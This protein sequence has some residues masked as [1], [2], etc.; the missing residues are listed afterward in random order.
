MNW[1]RHMHQAEDLAHAA[2]ALHAATECE[3]AEGAFVG[4]AGVVAAATATLAL[5]GLAL[6]PLG[7]GLA[8]GVGAT[9]GGTGLLKK[10]RQMLS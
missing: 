2:H 10:A 9:A 3:G 5:F 4:A 7:W 6:T 1:R 8:A